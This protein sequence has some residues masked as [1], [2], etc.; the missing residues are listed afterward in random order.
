MFLC[1]E[2]RPTFSWKDALR[3]LLPHIVDSRLASERYKKPYVLFTFCIFLYFYLF[4]FFYF[5]ISIYVFVYLYF[6]LDLGKPGDLIYGPR[7][8]KM[9]I[10]AY[11]LRCYDSL[12]L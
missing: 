8:Q 6:L 3:V 7:W 10:K 11:F 2:D 4:V 12:D 5:Y 1:F 9:V